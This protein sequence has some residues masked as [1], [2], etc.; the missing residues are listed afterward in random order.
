VTAA[1]GRWPLSGDPDASVGARHHR[2]PRF[3]LER[4]ANQQG[5]IT[6]VDRRTGA[7]WTASIDATA[8]EKDFYTVINTDGEK[9][10]KTEHLLSHIEGNAARAIRNIQAPAFRLFPPQPQDREDLCLFLAFQ[11]VR[12]KQ[13]RKRIEMLGD[14]W[15][16]AQIPANMTS[17]QAAE[18]LAAHDHEATP[19]AIG[20]M[21]DL[22]ASL[23]E[24]QFVPDPNEH[25][26]VMGST[27][28]RISE[29]L[30]PRPWYIAKYDSPALLTSD[31]P[32]A[33]H[34]RDASRP[35]G[36]DQG[37]AYA[38][39]IWFPL[40]PCRL[41]ILGSPGDP[42]PE[43]YLQP[44]AQT[45]ATVNLTIAAGA[46]EYIYMHPGQ[47]HLKEL[48]PPEPGPILQVR[49]QLPFDL[50][51]YNRPVTDTRTQRRR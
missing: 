1:S 17:G 8:A 47:D 5:Q 34:F 48:Q 14:L 35:P 38:D 18:W 25:L 49:G 33:L 40:D 6:T 3:Y 9:D 39:E 16:R 43:Q 21:V 22:S 27:A 41:L 12:G 24:F 37:I 13:T 32:V 26:R 11:K 7:R 30:L 45:A 2:V 20:E 31:E 15:A 44:P 23:D 29:L 28:L 50:G 51:R 10:G 42:L 4:F 46:Y 36:H 19:D